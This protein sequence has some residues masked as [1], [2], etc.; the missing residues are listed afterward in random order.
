MKEEEKPKLLQEL[1]DLIVRKFQMRRHLA[2]SEVKELLEKI[3]ELAEPDPLSGTAK[4]G[5]TKKC[6]DC[7]T[8]M[9]HSADYSHH[10]IDIFTCPECGCRI[11]VIHGHNHS[12]G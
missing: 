4:P 1:R 10:W 11:E 12:K 9:R 3:P 5:I 7:G 6:P 2:I 8:E